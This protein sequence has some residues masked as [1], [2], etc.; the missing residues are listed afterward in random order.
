MALNADG[1]G[2]PPRSSRV[3]VLIGE[4]IGWGASSFGHVAISIDRVVYSFGPSGMAIEPDHLY[5]NRNAFRSTSG[6]I[7]DVEPNLIP[8]MKE[9]LSTY[10]EEYSVIGFQ[11]CVQPVVYALGMGGVHV[12]TPIF[13]VSLGNQLIDSGRVRQV[14][15]YPQRVPRKVPPYYPTESAPW[16]R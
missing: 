16:A 2:S 5:L 14:N 8:D 7:V 6:L 13:P 15:Y 3:E 9:F 1:Y 4:P 11:A 12:D 10:S